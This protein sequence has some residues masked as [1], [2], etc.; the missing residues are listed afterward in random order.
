MTDNINIIIVKI[1]RKKFVLSVHTYIC[2]IWIVINYESSFYADPLPSCAILR[3]IIDDDVLQ[4]EKIDIAST[5]VFVRV[6][7]QILYTISEIPR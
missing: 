2:V 7:C 1:Y 5:V 3:R 6:I 4:G